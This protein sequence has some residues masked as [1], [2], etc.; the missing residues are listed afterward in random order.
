MK[1]SSSGRFGF[2]GVGIAFVLGLVVASAAMWIGSSVWSPADTSSGSASP[3]PIAET[4]Y[5][6]PTD[7]GEPESTSPAQAGT[8]AA[9]LEEIAE[10]DTEFSQRLALYKLA[11]ESSEAQLLDLID[12]TENL[13]T[14]LQI[15]WQKIFFDRLFEINPALTLSQLENIEPSLAQSIF[16]QWA[17]QNLDDAIAGV[18]SLDG[19]IRREASMGILTHR[20]DISPQLQGRI[21]R[22]L[23]VGE[24][25]SELASGQKVLD[26]RRDPEKAWNEA[27]QEGT[28]SSDQIRTLVVAAV[29]WIRQSGLDVIDRIDETLEDAQAREEIL[30]SVL[31]SALHFTNSEDVFKRALAMD[32]DPKKMLLS[33]V[34]GSWSRSDP[35]SALEAVNEVSAHSV[36]TQLQHTVIHNWARYDPR[37]VLNELDRFP[38]ET[39]ATAQGVALKTIAHSNPQEAILLTDN[40]SPGAD[41]STL[42]SEI[43]SIWAEQDSEAALAWVLSSQESMEAQS[44]LL[45]SVVTTWSRREPSQALNWV[46]EH[47]ELGFVREVTLPIILRNLADEDPELALQQALEQPMSAHGV[48]PEHTVISHIAQGDIQLAKA[49]LQR[50]REG[51]T[52]VNSYTAVG[53]AMVSTSRANEALELAADLFDSD[54]RGY[55]STILSQ[56]SKKD[57]QD[58]FERLSQISDT[59]IRSSAAAALI[60]RDRAYDI[61]TNDQI[62]YARKYLT[63]TEVETIRIIR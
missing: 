22:E 4:Q 58:L 32:S 53:I 57:P 9:T 47:R 18:K 28:Y 49:M 46:I 15:Q 29:S 42:V 48:G 11:L 51:Q 27:L 43:A 14:Q 20:P 61:L 56:W 17:R 13:P 30:T 40:L 55:V 6:E 52:R 31:L 16:R 63:D 59:E 54:R 34:V 1:S 2:L 21:A 5:S 7:P 19:A 36:R 62:E 25:S 38:T 33:T 45:T 35:H 44:K 24:L 60:D 12:Q 41:K 10:I 50:T 26:I 39:Q 37:S 3:D 23:G 8:S